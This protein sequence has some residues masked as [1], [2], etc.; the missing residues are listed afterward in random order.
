MPL[1]SM[2]ITTGAP[3]TEV[4]VLTFSTVGASAV[5]AIEMFCTKKD[6]KTAP[7]FEKAAA[8][9]AA[10]GDEPFAELKKLDAEAEAKKSASVA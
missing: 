2:K 4:T 10:L 7:F 1:I 9:R 8:L 3:K 6:A 5:R